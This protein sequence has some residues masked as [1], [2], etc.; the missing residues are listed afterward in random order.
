MNEAKKSKI[1]HLV[2]Q[3]ISTKDDDTLNEIYKKLFA[4]YRNKL[5]YWNATTSTI[6]NH[7]TQA[8]FDDTLISILQYIEEKG[9]DFVKMFQQRLTSKKTDLLRR[10]IVKRKHEQYEV[11]ND[12]ENA[13]TFEIASDFNL[14]ED[15]A[16]RMYAKQKDDQRQL[17][18][19]LVRGENARTTAIV[20]AYL[21]TDHKTPT[22]IGRHLG[23][24]HKQVSRAL[25]RLA[26]KYDT[27]QFGDYTD[28]LVAL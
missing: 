8:I 16:A 24:D 2:T 12:D 7:E 10:I 26:S 11:D 27:K 13:A 5:D 4:E 3:Y 20:Q 15:V 18:D 23:L 22:A 17:I 21:T 28:Y 14:E 25:T 1:N 9:G 6:S 19:F